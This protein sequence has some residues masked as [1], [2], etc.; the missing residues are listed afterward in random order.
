M[1][2]YGF[3][4]EPRAVEHNRGKKSL[5]RDEY[6]EENLQP[7]NVMFDRRVVRGNTYAAQ[8]VAVNAHAEADRIHQAQLAE[9]RRREKMKRLRMGNIVRPGTPEAVAGRKHTEVQTGLYLEELTDKVPESN[10]ETQ[11]ESFLD[12]PPSPLFMPAKI[13]LDVATQVL[14]GELFDFSLEV[15]PI[16]E[17]LV[18]K[19]LEQSMMEVLEEEELSNIRAHQA[20]FE[21]IRNAELAEVQR[22]EAEAFRK[23]EEKERRVN[24]EE[25]RVSRETALNDKISARSFAKNYL[26]DLH[27]NVF[28]KLLDTGHFFDPLAREVEV[29]FM[30]WLLEAMSTNIKSSTTA[31]QLVDSLLMNALNIANTIHSKKV[32]LEEA[33][34]AEIAAFDDE[35]NR[36]EEEALAAA[37]AEEVGDEVK[38][39]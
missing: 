28:N 22:L 6:E 10:A 5:Y 1:S 33:R 31:R 30:P 9:R 3:A 23:Y 32:A 27:D 38:E 8:H 37:A 14:P 35:A 24:Q 12:R 34:I 4:A 20:E 15:E 39:E 17:V 16:L 7:Q 19:T 11:T 18:G 21:Q 25:K 36:L 29:D 26:S 2:T 13:G